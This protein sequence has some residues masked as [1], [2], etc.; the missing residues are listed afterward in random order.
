M[1]RADLEDSRE[2]FLTVEMISRS[3]DRAMEGGVLSGTRCDSEG[4]QVGALGAR[5]A[6]WLLRALPPFGFLLF[7]RD[8]RAWPLGSVKG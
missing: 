4:G 3:N 8:F 5:A 7:R 2:R 1:D 6:P